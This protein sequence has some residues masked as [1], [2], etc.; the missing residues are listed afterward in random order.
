[1]S[2]PESHGVMD[3][4]ERLRTALKNKR[5][6]ID[7]DRDPTYDVAMWEAAQILARGSHGRS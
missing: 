3:E 5:I 4:T 6:K 1:M 7:P 2:Q